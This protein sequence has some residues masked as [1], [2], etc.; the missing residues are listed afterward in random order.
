MAAPGG[1]V[2]GFRIESET[3][4]YPVLTTPRH[5]D[6]YRA[7]TLPSRERGLPLLEAIEGSQIGE[8]AR[9]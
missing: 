2:H 7:I 8:A 9:E 1:T 5:G 3:A 6:V 4:R